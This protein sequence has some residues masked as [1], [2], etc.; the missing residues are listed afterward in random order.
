MIQHTPMM[1]QG[2]KQNSNFRDSNSNNRTVS[3]RDTQGL[4]T[5]NNNICNRGA[6]GFGEAG[7]CGQVAKIDQRKMRKQAS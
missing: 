2:P 3:A 1:T 6:G 4:G 5:E 7:G